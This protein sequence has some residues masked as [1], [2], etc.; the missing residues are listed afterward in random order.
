MRYRILKKA[1]YSAF[2]CACIS[3]VA[4]ECL[5]PKPHH[6]TRAQV[7]K[8]IDGDTLLLTDGRRL[9]MLYVDAP[10]LNTATKKHA[11]PYARSAKS[12]LQK[13]LPKGS[14]IYL[15][16]GQRKRDRFKRVLAQVYD[17]ERRYLA[18]EL[19]DAGLAQL[20]K[21]P[22]DNYPP[23]CLVDA[24]KQAR[25]HKKAIWN[26]KLT[27][28]I[29]ASQ[30]KGAERKVIVEGRVSRRWQKGKRYYLM[31]DK[32]LLVSFEHSELFAASLYEK[33]Q[34]DSRIVLRGFAYR[35]GRQWRMK[36][37]HAADVFVPEIE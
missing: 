9:R 28:P 14:T 3:T 21:I 5:T 15:A 18:A 26:S 27:A 31:L 16:V 35:H 10:E 37:K 25:I 22:P 33:A 19:L 13:R 1:L 24:E 17:L 11:E 20:I 12:W 30:L 36:I 29:A 7:T 6:L 34:K 23:Q 8:V 32:R 2:F 4:A